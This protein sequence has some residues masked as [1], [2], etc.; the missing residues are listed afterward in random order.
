MI[1][2]LLSTN[3][4]DL[5]LSDKLLIIGSCLE[6]KNPELVAEIA[7]KYDGHVLKI[8]LEEMHYNQYM[9]KMQA[10]LGLGKIKEVGLLTVD[11]SPHCC[12][13][14]FGRKYLERQLKT[15]VKFSHY[16]ISTKGEIRKIE[17]HLVDNAKVFIK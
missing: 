6:Q 3:I 5:M 9:A 7:A 8:C 2:N 11:G 15:S 12:Q 13:I 14:H 10:I 17:P 16:V 1:G 4:Y